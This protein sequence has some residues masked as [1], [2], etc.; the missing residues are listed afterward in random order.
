MDNEHGR[1]CSAIA[2]D[3]NVIDLVIHLHAILTQLR[4]PLPPAL[5]SLPVYVLSR[6]P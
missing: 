5:A 2:R 3:E 4:L 1:L 6:L